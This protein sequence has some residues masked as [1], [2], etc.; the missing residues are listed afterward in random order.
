MNGGD[1][2]ETL[3]NQAVT[4]TVWSETTENSGR[5]TGAALWMLQ[6]SF[7]KLLCVRRCH[8]PPSSLNT[9]SSHCCSETLALAAFRRR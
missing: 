4:C 2:F 3:G 7:S 6:S 1:Y 5:S 8:T 9:Q